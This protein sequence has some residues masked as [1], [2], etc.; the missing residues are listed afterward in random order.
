MFSTSVCVCVSYHEEDLLQPLDAV[1]IP[2]R[3][4]VHAARLAA[5]QVL[6][7]QHDETLQQETGQNK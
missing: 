2:G 6:C 3:A 4:D 1:F 5:H 7:Q